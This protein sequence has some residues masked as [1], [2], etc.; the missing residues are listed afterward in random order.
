MKSV[1]FAFSVFQVCKS[2]GRG[3]KGGGGGVQ[4]FYVFFKAKKKNQKNDI[5]FS[6]FPITIFK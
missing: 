5:I 6:D 4:F 3:R 2:A 1:F